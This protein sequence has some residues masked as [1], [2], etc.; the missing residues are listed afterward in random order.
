MKR[1]FGLLALIA[2][3]AGP[4]WALCQEQPRQARVTLP[5]QFDK[6]QDSA[7]FQ[8]DVAVL[9]YGDR[10][11]MP[12]N[13]ELGTRLQVQFH[14]TAAGLAP[15]AASKQP[16]KPLAGLPMGK[17]SPDVRV[18]PVACIGDVPNLVKKV[19]R[20]QVKKEAPDVPVWLD[21]G[22]TMSKTFGM[23]EGQPN[24][25][26]LDAWGRVR[27]RAAGKVDAKTYARLVEVIDYLRKEA[28]GLTQ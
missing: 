23:V 22:E 8:G 9:L 5:D 17:R 16:A 18:V 21:F 24:L 26:V 20:N 6:M 27:Y 11:G 28:A 2:L 19:I 14:P 12:A 3:L 15:G 13:K 4:A 25:V 10:T 7:Q 1:Y